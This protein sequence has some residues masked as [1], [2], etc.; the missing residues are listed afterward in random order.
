MF[1]PKYKYALEKLNQVERVLTL[2]PFDIRKRLTSA[3]PSMSMLTSDDL[4]KHLRKKYDKIMNRLTKRGPLLRSDGEIIYG[5]LENTMKGSTNKTTA[6]IAA[7][8]IE[9][10]DDLEL[11]IEENSLYSNK[12]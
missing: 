7:D 2:N 9:L 4:P 5:A 8:L 6:R 1:N 12:H 10:K 3:Y 11:Y